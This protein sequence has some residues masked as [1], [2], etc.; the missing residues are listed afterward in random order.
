MTSAPLLA[1]EI[2]VWDRRFFSGGGPHFEY[3]VVGGGRV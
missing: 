2:W 3:S 1:G